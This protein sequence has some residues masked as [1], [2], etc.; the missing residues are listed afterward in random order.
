MKVVSLSVVRIN[1]YA[2]AGKY[3]PTFLKY[4]SFDVRDCK[5]SRTSKFIRRIKRVFRFKNLHNTLLNYLLTYFMGQSPSWE[6]N[7]SSYRQGIPH[8]LWNPKIHC[9]VYKC[10]LPVPILSQID[11]VHT[12]LSHFVKTLLNITLPS[13]CGSSKWSLSLRFPHQYPLTK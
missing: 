11:P 12:P 7:S 6:A 9:R 3:W 13:T 5:P 1:P 10:L 2:C 8:I 4:N